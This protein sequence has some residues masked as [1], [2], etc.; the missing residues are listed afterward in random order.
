MRTCVV[1]HQLNNWLHE[2]DR[3]EA[4]AEAL[5]ARIAESMQL[6][7]EYDPLEPKNFSEGLGEL[8]DQELAVIAGL[9]RCN[10]H[11]QAAK[12]MEAAIRSHWIKLAAKAAEIALEPEFY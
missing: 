1:T 9:M 2:Q 11:E 3:Q 10:K 6:G 12:L 5:E 8:S 7:G 4:M